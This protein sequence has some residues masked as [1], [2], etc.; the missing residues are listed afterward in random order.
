MMVPI[1]VLSHG[2]MAVP[3]QHTLVSTK[4]LKYILQDLFRYI[5]I[6]QFAHYTFEYLKTLSNGPSF[7][8]I[9]LHMHSM[10][11]VVRIRVIF[12]D[13]ASSVKIVCIHIIHNRRT[14]VIQN[15]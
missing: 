10:Y 14:G 8:M 9:C 4:Y 12:L 13:N 3:D 6:I 15:V 1:S 7:K 2:D 5:Y 11:L